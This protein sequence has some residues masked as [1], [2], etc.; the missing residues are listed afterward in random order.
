[1][2]PV[3]ADEIEVSLFGPGYGESLVVHLA[4]DEWVVIDSCLNPKTKRPAALTYFEQTGVD[5][6]T[7]VRL[8][9]AT[10][11]HD[12]HIRGLHEL[13][14]ACPAADFVCA[15]ALTQREFVAM[16]T[17]FEQGNKLAGGSGVTELSRIMDTLKKRKQ[18]PIYAA[19]NLPVLQRVSATPIPYTVTTLSPAHAEV[20]RFWYRLA[21]RIKLPGL[22]QTKR[23]ISAG[24][25]NHL[26]IAIWI[27]VG[28]ESFL[29]GSDLEETT[30]SSTGW[31]V[32]V[33]SPLRPLG[34][35]AIFKIPH[36]G[37]QTA[38][39]SP[40]WQQMIKRDA[41]AIM[42]PFSKGNVQLPATADIRR[43]GGHTDKV[44]ITAEK[45][46]QNAVVRPAVVQRQIK[47][48][49]K[50]LKAING[51]FGHLRLRKRLGNG[52]RWRIATIGDAK[53]L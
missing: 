43:I 12:D 47:Q 19:P 36:H 39:N 8:I 18:Q 20:T 41:Y 34:A 44:F 9:V 35:A 22:R 29:L 46:S 16:V 25:Q 11:W 40:V 14:E 17:Q 6:S 21:S 7:T 15:S 13:V 45:A 4:G 50:S 1:M 33:N 30:D 24:K 37:S 31:S 48:T 10:H 2:Q 28:D 32:I 53:R 51:Q 42:T 5:P 27:R 52:Y 49:V 38:H 3:K 26:A 23:R